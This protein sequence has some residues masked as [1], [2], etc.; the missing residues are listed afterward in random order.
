[1]AGM[2]RNPFA[3][4]T[5]AAVTV[6]HGVVLYAGNQAVLQPPQPLPVVVMQMA[7]IP[8]SADAAALVSAPAVTPAHVPPSSVRPAS[9]TATRPASLPVAPAPVSQQQGEVAPDKATKTGSKAAAAAEGKSDT[10]ATP[11]EGQASLT[12]PQYRGDYLHNP[13]PAYP[14]LSLE[15]GEQGTAE[16]RV[17]VS[18]SGEALSVELA[19]SSGYPR[20]DRAAREAVQRWRFLPARRGTQAV[21]HSFV[22]PVNFSLKSAQ[23]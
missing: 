9:N 3:I 1:M 2:K 11:Q 15:L 20:L 21:A 5:L 4:A 17:E 16:F 14:P 13:K 19:K 6:L 12:L 18:A 10:A 22:V 23:S 8:A 7:S